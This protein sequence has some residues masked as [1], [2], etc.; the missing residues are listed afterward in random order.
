MISPFPNQTSIIWPD[1][2]TKSLLYS[3]ASFGNIEAC[4]SRLSLKP[5]KGNKD[6]LFHLFDWTASQEKKTKTLFEKWDK[7]VSSESWFQV[8]ASP[9]HPGG[10]TLCVSISTMHAWD[11]SSSLRVAQLSAT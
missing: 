3:G 7:M 8:S 4:D 5:G 10:S 1:K 2:I 6:E 11:S 9:K